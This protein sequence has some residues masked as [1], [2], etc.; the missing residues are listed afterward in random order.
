MLV[1]CPNCKKETEFVGNPFRPF[2]SERCKL[3]DLGAWVDEEY[4][5]PSDQEVLSEED[6]KLIQERSRE[7]D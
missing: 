5:I 7:N 6:I 4:K 3:I 2:C 1:K